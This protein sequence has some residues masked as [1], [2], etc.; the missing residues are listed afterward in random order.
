MEKLRHVPSNEACFQ[1][2][3]MENHANISAIMRLNPSAIKLA[4]CARRKVNGEQRHQDMVSEPLKAPASAKTR[5]GSLSS[6]VNFQNSQIRQNALFAEEQKNSSEDSLLAHPEHD[7]RE[8]LSSGNKSW[9]SEIYD[10]IF[11]QKLEP[12][13]ST[14]YRLRHVPAPQFANKHPWRLP[15]AFILVLLADIGLSF[16]ILIQYFCIQ[17]NDPDSHDS[18]C[19]HVSFP[20]QMPILYAINTTLCR[21]HSTVFLDLNQWRW[22]ELHYWVCFLYP[23]R[24]SVSESWYAI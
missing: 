17:V 23:S 1:R 5:L 3:N 24:T 7:Y 8:A 6:E 21:W 4:C 12:I 10:R 14:V 20:I 13:V 19:S 16:W 22:W 9:F 15:S 18:G 11:Y 2:I